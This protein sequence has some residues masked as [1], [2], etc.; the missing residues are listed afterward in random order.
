MKSWLIFGDT[1]KM[2]T[3]MED[4]KF[5]DSNSEKVL[6]MSWTPKIDIFKFNVK[7]TMSG[8]T[9]YKYIPDIVTPRMMLS[10]IARI[11]DPGG[12]LAPFVIEVQTLM[13]KSLVMEDSMNDQV[14]GEDKW[15]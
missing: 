5:V 14:E 7:W 10:Q 8:G 2:T 9:K 3:E 6:G 1:S 13:R 12:L 4:I 11:Y 15:D